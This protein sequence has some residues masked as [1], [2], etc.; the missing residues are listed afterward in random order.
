MLQG[1]LAAGLMLLLSNHA[2]GVASLAIV[3]NHGNFA[4]AA[5]Q[6][7]QLLPAVHL[8]SGIPQWLLVAIVAQCHVSHWSLSHE[9]TVL[10][11][12]SKMHQEFVPHQPSQGVQMMHLFPVYSVS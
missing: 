8:W 9:S 11:D 3:Q 1:C 2:C 7:A 12:F 5:L 6:P 4:L 10:V